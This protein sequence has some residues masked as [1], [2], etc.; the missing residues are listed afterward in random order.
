[1]YFTL[2]CMVLFMNGL[3]LFMDYKLFFPNFKNKLVYYRWN[4][5][6]RMIGSITVT[7]HMLL[8]LIQGML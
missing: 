6:L 7:S 4:L 2:S 8:I 5:F 1:M 3:A